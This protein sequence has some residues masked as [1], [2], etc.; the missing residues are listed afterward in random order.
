[1]VR[2][3]ALAVAILALCSC[4]GHGQQASTHLS[5]G[6]NAI[7]VTYGPCKGTTAALN[8]A[9]RRIPL[10]HGMVVQARVGDPINVSTLSGC[11]G[12]FGLGYRDLG[13][14][15]PSSSG[16]WIADESGSLTVSLDYDGCI[17]NGCSGPVGSAGTFT[18][19]IR[20]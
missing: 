5:P 4:A 12:E 7:A 11:P 17:P 18:L 1:M 13:L 14:L 19:R 15:G 16:A 8:V 20:R 6:P 10:L 9:G 3:A 2:V